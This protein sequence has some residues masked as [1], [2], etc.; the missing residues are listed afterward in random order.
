[1]FK[2]VIAVSVAL[3]ALTAA[4]EPP[5]SEK[6]PA[7]EPGPIMAA[8]TFPEN[9]GEQSIFLVTGQVVEVTLPGN[10]TT[11][12]GWTLEK[13]EA[14]DILARPM[15]ADFQSAAPQRVGAGGVFKF[16]F[17]AARAG[18]TTIRFLY[19]RAWEKDVA[20]LYIADLRVTAE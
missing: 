8:V 9:G 13:F 3:A 11:G 5:A 16:R 10:P 19:R 6:A 2:L 17:T 18:T 12:Y 7:P 1:M 4:G 14:Q 20:P 15:E